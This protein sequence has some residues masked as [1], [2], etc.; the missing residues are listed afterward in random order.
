MGKNNKKDKYNEAVKLLNEGKKRGA[1]PSQRTAETVVSYASTIDEAMK[2]ITAF[3][4]RGVQA[5][6]K[7]LGVTLNLA[8]DKAEALSIVK[9]FQVKGV[10][11]DNYALNRIVSLCKDQTEAVPIINHYNAEGVKPTPATIAALIKVSSTTEFADMII[12]KSFDN[13]VVEPN[14]YALNARLT[15]CSTLK[16]MNYISE[17]MKRAYGLKA[18]AISSSI[19]IKKALDEKDYDAAER[20][21]ATAKDFPN[22]SG[23]TNTIL[24]RYENQI[25]AVRRKQEA[26]KK[27]SPAD[28]TGDDIFGLDADTKTVDADKKEEKTEKEPEDIFA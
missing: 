28:Y 5:S 8:K 3:E 23:K 6:Q 9:Q 2:L 26:E 21:L 13:K 7:M 24:K 12:K 27:P 1:Y 17:E 20:E 10:N 25:I 14:A 18:D 4:G 15:L 11:V 19:K 22:N 16:E